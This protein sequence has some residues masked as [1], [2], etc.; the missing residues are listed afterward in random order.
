MGVE[1]RARVLALVAA[2]AAAPLRLDA[3]DA[4]PALHQVVEAAMRTAAGLASDDAARTERLRASHWAPVLRAQ[5]GLRDDQRTRRGEVRLAPLVED[6]AGTSRAWAVV[7]QW[8]L[9]QL[10]YS[11]DESQLALAQVHLARVRQQAAAEAARLYEERLRRR[12]QLRAMEPGR[13]PERWEA[14]LGLLRATAELDARTSGLFRSQL[15]AA[16]AL[17]DELAPPRPAPAPPPRDSAAPGAAADP[18]PRDPIPV[19]P[20]AG[21]AEEELP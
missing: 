6:D 2:A 20:R 5:G 3:G 13:G 14:V 1:V 9:A 16:Q 19:P 4:E 7:L 11:R 8:D 21:G 12:V 10:V 17:L 18:G 15:Q